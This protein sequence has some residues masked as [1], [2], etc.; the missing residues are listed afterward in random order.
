MQIPCALKSKKQK[1]IYEI[2]CQIPV[3]FYWVNECINYNFK[4]INKWLHG[5]LPKLNVKK[6]N[7]ISK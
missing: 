2:L 3:K 6:K 7:H 4:T 1:K 5:P